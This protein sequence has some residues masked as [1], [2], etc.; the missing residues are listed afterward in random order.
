MI[1]FPIEEN[2]LGERAVVR[3]FPLQPTLRRIPWNVALSHVAV[4][5][6]DLL[7]SLTSPSFSDGKKRHQIHQKAA[8]IMPLF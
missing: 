7:L 3:I 5:R 4:P 1:V 2:R 6:S 8:F